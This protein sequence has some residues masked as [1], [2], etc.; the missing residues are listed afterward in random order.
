MVGALLAGGPLLARI[1]EIALPAGMIELK[2]TRDDLTVRAL[3]IQIRCVRAATEAERQRT[4]MPYATCHGFAINGTETRHG[5]VLELQAIQPNKVQ[6]EPQLIRFSD[7]DQGHPCMAVRAIFNEVS[8][9]QDVEL[10]VN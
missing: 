8:P 6:L 3:W 9:Q 4:G 1:V 7:E 5:T 2:P 10:Y